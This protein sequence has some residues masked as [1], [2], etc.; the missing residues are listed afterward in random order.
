M[1]KFK[2]MA[3]CGIK[4]DIV[5]YNAL[6][7]GMADT[8]RYI[9]PNDLT[10]STLI[11]IYTKGRMYAEAMDVYRVFKQEGMVLSLMLYAKIDKYGDLELCNVGFDTSFQANEHQFEPSSS[12]M[13]Q[14]QKIDDED[15]DDI[16]KM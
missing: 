13:F 8:T 6:I 7:R 15:N 16:M 10:Y 4:T 2:E 1:G 9:Y 3:N 14:D 5:T 12:S 11:K